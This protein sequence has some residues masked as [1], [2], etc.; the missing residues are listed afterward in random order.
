MTSRY[1]E[2]RSGASFR[3][4]ASSQAVRRIDA[5][6]GLPLLAGLLL[7]A[8]FVI[9]LAGRHEAQLIRA[10]RLQQEIVGR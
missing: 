1:F 4:S 8:G 2:A 3:T 6:G 7:A 5:I 10:E 9:W